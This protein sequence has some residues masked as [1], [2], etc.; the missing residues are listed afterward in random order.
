MESAEYQGLKKTLKWNRLNISKI[1]NEPYFRYL[2]ASWRLVTFTQFS[3]DILYE[4]FKNR[5]T[6]EKEM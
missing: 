1:Q 3:R 4:H 6:R 5:F 2:K